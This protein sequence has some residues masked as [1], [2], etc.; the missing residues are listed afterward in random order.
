V[1]VRLIGSEG[2]DIEG[3]MFLETDGEGTLKDV[4]W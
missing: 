1:V 4:L 3:G 2:D